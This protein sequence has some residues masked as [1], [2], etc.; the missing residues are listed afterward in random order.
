MYRPGSRAKL[1]KTTT[2]LALVSAAPRT[3]CLLEAENA[4]TLSL[5]CSRSSRKPSIQPLGQLGFSFYEFPFKL[6][7]T[8][9]PASILPK[10]MLSQAFLNAHSRLVSFL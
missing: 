8:L 4:G 3:M 10:L 9:N 7:T 6:S 2:F 1:L 5:H